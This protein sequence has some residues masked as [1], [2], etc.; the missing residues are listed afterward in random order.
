[1]SSFLMRDAQASDNAGLLRLL[2]VAQPS[3][4]LM[5]TFERAPD[6]FH[7]VSVTHEK[8]QVLVAERKGDGEIVGVA[9]FGTRQLFINGEEQAVRYGSD[10]RIAA[11]HQGS[12][13][14]IYITRAVR[15][16]LQEKGW[17]QAIILEDNQRTREVLEGARAGLPQYRA[18]TGL[19]TWT[20]S[21]RKLKAAL[22]SGLSARKATADDIPAMNAFLRRMAAHYQFLPAY[23]FSG[24]VQDQPYFRGLALDDFLLITDAEGIR[25]MVALWNQ[26]AFK[27][28]RVVAYNALMAF[29]RPFYNLWARSFGG[30]VLPPAGEAFSYRVLHSLLSAPDDLAA[31]DAL[32]DAA[33][34]ESGKRDVA[35]GCA[36]T[37][38]TLSL[39]DSDPR[40]T[41]LS[42]FRALSLRGRHYTVAFNAAAHPELDSTRIPYFECGRL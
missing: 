36:R 21:G 10:L 7:S 18:H 41:V 11:E 37:A 35:A 27:Q 9:S 5:L 2:G 1:M 8:P 33:W 25:G 29:L 40:R 4:G 30:F 17:Y 23:D 28:T 42:R 15:E 20:L 34:E 39:A 32:L 12:R 16:V 6:Y 3:R 24:L 13:L 22:A 31:F 38:L 19:E 26:K 14:M